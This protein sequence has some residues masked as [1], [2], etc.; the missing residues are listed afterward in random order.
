MSEATALSD[1]APP[2]EEAVDAENP[3]REAVDRF[4]SLIDEMDHIR[5]NLR[6]AGLPL[7]TTRMIVE[8]GVQDKKDQRDQ[9]IDAAMTTSVESVYSREEVAQ[10]ISQVVELEKAY[11]EARSVARERNL[12][13]QALGVLTQMI[14]QNPGDRG[15][16]AVT[17]FVGY[18]I[19]CD[20]SL[21]NIGAVV[22]GLEAAKASVLPVVD[23]TTLANPGQTGRAVVMDILVGVAFSIAALWLLV[24]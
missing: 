12:D 18:A 19:A 16:N 17:T 11:T 20:I 15:E 2:S 13:V 22:R 9:A 6:A 21:D 5:E 8:F 1:S 4:C 14:Q 3:V 24:K 7:R 10:Q 23:R